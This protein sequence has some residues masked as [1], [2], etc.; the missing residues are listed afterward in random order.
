MD[1][2]HIE[3]NELLKKN[4]KKLLCS[5]ISLL[6]YA[7]AYAN[8]SGTTIGRVKFTN[9]PCLPAHAQSPRTSS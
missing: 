7:A 6:L 1:S 9:F 2:V 8:A 4:Y 3:M 5:S